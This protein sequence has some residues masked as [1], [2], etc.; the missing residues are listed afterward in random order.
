MQR[1]VP[2]IG[3]ALAGPPPP[4]APT[5][6]LQKGP[7][8]KKEFIPFKIAVG[9]PMTRE[10]FE[11]AA[12]LQVFGIAAIPSQWHNVNDAYTPADSPVAT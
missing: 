8:G 12:N 11:A 3:A 1:K 9:K 2:G 5:G 6:Q 10:E 7:K 4:L